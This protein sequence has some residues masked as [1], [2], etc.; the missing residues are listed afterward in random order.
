MSSVAQAF[1]DFKVV[2]KVTE[3]YSVIGKQLSFKDAVFEVATFREHDGLATSVKT[4]IE[5]HKKPMRD[6]F[7][8]VLRMARKSQGL[9][10]S[11]SQFVVSKRITD[12]ECS[13]TASEVVCATS[14]EF[15]F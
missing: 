2:S 3:S 15:S 11:K 14:Y 12:P 13:E 5:T 4:R 10:Q 8:Q 1:H 7:N 9:K 6:P